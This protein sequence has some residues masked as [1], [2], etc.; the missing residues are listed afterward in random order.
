MQSSNEKYYNMDVATTEQLLRLIQSILSK[1]AWINATQQYTSLTDIITRKWSGKKT[2]KYE[3]L[4]ICKKENLRDH[5]TNTELILNIL[6]EAASTDFVKEKI[7]R[8]WQK[9]QK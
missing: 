6:T 7:Q 3:V 8:A 4:K 2:K 5:R 1:R 9:Q